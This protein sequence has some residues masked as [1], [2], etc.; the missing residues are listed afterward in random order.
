VL[1]VRYSEY[2]DAHQLSHGSTNHGMQS[3]DPAKRLEPWT[4]Y[5]RMG[6]VGEIFG[7]LKEKGPLEEIGVI[8]LGT[9]SIAAYGKPGRRIT[10]YEIDPAVLYIARDS[11]LFSY[12]TDSLSDVDCV[13]GDAR[14]SLAAEAARGEPRE[15]DLLMVDAFSSDAIP[16]HLL[17]REALALYF[18][19]L[20]EHGVL[21][22]HIS[23]R[24]LDLEPVLGNLAVDAGHV[25]RVCED[26]KEERL[27]KFASTWVVLARR[28]AD[29]GRLAGRRAKDAD[30]QWQ[31]WLDEKEAQDTDLEEFNE[32]LDLL[33]G[34]KRWKPI[35]TDPQKRLWTD[36]YSNVIDVIDLDID[37]SW[38]VPW[39]ASDSDQ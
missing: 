38:L 17:T 29:L 32:A 21:A 9:G 7:V 37:L 20:A 2:Y 10:F 16:V 4:Y 8:G 6:P 36:N 31:D 35:R 25:A 39:S 15:F 19:H 28:E 34:D 33:L 1:R 11:G 3:V 24:H 13:L 18:E 14:Q 22:V 12:L 23:N 5:H 30:Q 26:G 27:G